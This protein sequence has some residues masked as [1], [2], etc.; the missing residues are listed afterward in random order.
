MSRKMDSVVQPAYER[1]SRAGSHTLD[2]TAVGNVRSTT[3]LSLDIGR[4]HGNMNAFR[5]PIPKLT[6]G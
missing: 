2:T 5:R 4:K 3:S 6:G 1:D